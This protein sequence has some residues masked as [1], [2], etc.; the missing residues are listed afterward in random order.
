MWTKRFW[1]DAGERAVRTF[2]QSLLALL[3]GSATDLIHTAWPADLS[4]AAMATV[5]SLLTSIVASG[6]GSSTSAALITPSKTST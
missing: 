1:V 4:I 2:A 5:L 6:V 3:T